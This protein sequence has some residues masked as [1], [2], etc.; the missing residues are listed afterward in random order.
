LIGEHYRLAEGPAGCR[1]RYRIVSHA[2]VALVRALADNTGLTAGLSKALASHRLLVRDRGRMVA[3]LAC[4]IADGAEVISDFRVFGDQGE[5]F[6]LTV[7]VPTAWRTLNEVARGGERA[8]GRISAAVN[9]ARRAARH[10]GGGQDASGRG[11]E[12]FRQ[13]VLARIHRARQQ[14][15][16]AAGPGRGGRR[17]AVVSHPRP[18]PA[19]L[20]GRAVAAGPV[21]GV[22]H[23]ARLGPASLVLYDVSTLYFEAGQGAG[24]R[25]SGFSKE[26]RL[27][28]QITIGLLTG[29]DGFPLMVSAFEGNKKDE[30]HAA[31]HREV[32]DRPPAP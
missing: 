25:E 23:A 1:G 11:D 20:G 26:R 22:R 32:H 2:G 24:F 18:A 13:L 30:D 8:L 17:R 16:L 9:A 3:D 21:R 31:G 14:A 27:E 4:A 29:Q 19:G 28:P 10:P 6:G 12:V 5:L 15:G 7:S